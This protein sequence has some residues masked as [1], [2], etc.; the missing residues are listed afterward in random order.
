[1]SHTSIDQSA[2]ILR[3]GKRADEITDEAVEVRARELAL[4]DG[5]SPREITGE[6]RR[7]A[8]AELRGDL[9]PE[10]SFDN[11][12][13]D[14]GLSRDP[15]EPR[16]ISGERRPILN[17]PEDQEMQERLV[18]EGVEEA[19]HDQMLAARRRRET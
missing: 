13:A 3:H 6:D 9:L 14:A 10:T 11:R 15:A 1:M 17:E 2:R 19:Q 18:L 5:R 8:L 16:S 4:I 7:R 12:E